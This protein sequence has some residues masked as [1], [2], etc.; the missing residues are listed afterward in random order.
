MQLRAELQISVMIRA[1]SEVIIPAID[2]DNRLAV[3]Q[4]QVLLGMLRL[5]QRQLP[6]QFR[7]DRDE[8][9]RL[10]LFADRLER[11]CAND[12]SLREHGE[13]LTALAA[14]ARDRLARSAVEPSELWGASRALREA[15]GDLVSEASEFAAAET[16]AAI[17]REVLDLSREQLLRDRALLAPQGFEPLSNLPPI[18]DLLKVPATDERTER[19]GQ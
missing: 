18:D 11:L 19:N 3:E 8:L 7:F 5:M 13:Q 14:S 12:P 15:I 1:M 16:M 9:G 2:P 10:A 6:L 17:E 4:S